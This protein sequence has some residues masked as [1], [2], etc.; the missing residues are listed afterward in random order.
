ML[1]RRAKKHPICGDFENRIRLGRMDRRNRKL[2]RRKHDVL[3]LTQLSKQG[4]PLSHSAHWV[5]GIASTSIAILDQIIGRIYQRQGWIFRI[6][7]ILLGP[8]P[9]G[10]Q[11]TS[12]VQ[13]HSVRWVRGFLDHIGFLPN[14]TYNPVFDAFGNFCRY[15]R[16]YDRWFLQGRTIGLE[17]FQPFRH[18]KHLRAK[19]LIR[20]ELK[21]T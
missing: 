5:L 4:S 14:R 15:P 11:Q 20:S 6:H 19:Q 12:N 9:I 21:N 8:F 13:F 17:A 18:W 3:V 16:I 2:Y 1:E 7:I 10:D